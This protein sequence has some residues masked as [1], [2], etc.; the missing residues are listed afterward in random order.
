MN[1]FTVLCILGFMFSFGAACVW[2]RKRTVAEAAVMGAVLFFFTYIFG[3]MALFVIDRFSLFRA[4]AA[5]LALDISA[6]GAAVFVRRSK[7]FRLKKLIDLD[8][9]VKDMLIPL[10]V[11]IAAV[12]FVS[13]KNEIFGMGQ[14]QGVYQVQALNFMYDDNAR[15]KDIEEYHLLDDPEAKAHFEYKV[16]SMGGYDIQNHDYPE[17]VYDYNIS[18]VSGIFHGIPTYTSMLAMW[19]TLFGAENMADIETVFYILTIFL[20]YYVCR[21]LKL[22]A[23]SRICACVLTAFAPV[24][25]WVAKSTLTEMFLAV[26][27]IS[28]M[29][30]ITDD[31]QPKEKWMSVIPAA[32]FGCYHVSVFTMLPLFVMIYGGMYIFTREKQYAILTPAVTAGYL[33]SFFMMKQVQPMYTMNNYR[34]IFVGGINVNN[35]TT[36][37]T[38]FSLG[39]I[40]LS[41]GFIFIVSRTN[42]SFRAVK[43]N[44]KMA[45]NRPFRIFAALMLIIPLAFT[46]FKILRKYDSWDDASHAA[47]F[48]FGVNA[49]LVFVGLGGLLALFTTGRFIEKNSRLVVFVMF[50]YCVLIYSA[51]LRFEIQYYYYYSRYLAP[52]IPVAVIFAAL[53]LDRMGGRVL[54]P[55]AALSLVLNLPYIRWQK[56]A[57]DDTRMEWNVLEDITDVVDEDSCVVICSRYAPELWFP[58]RT[59]TDADVYPLNESDTDQFLELKRQYDKVFYIS[60]KDQPGD[61]FEIRYK[62]IV[63]HSEDDLNNTG[64]FVPM[65][66]KYME[67]QDDIYVYSYEKYKLLYEAAEDYRYFTGFSGIEGSFCWTAHE[68]TEIQGRLYPADYTAALSFGTVIPFDFLDTEEISVTMYINGEPVGTAAITPENNC[69]DITFDVP[70]ELIRDGKNVIGFETDMWNTSSVN[71]DDNRIVGIPLASVAFEEIGY[72]RPT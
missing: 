10:A 44:K 28:F 53:S 6:L 36:V 37:V 72:S 54:Y 68:K 30:F 55:A 24:V 67:V 4:A 61:G 25:I 40:V 66:L 70:E 21:N 26:I 17:T 13:V 12:P 19:G 2:L 1:T 41:C 5:A 43:F 60:D 8:M 42:K 11:C 58:L 33:A 22:K 15:Q 9:S 39:L 7:P 50:F 51:F 52:F 38:A 63:N 32:V 34:D 20:V 14:D 57:K 49:G 46:A 71:P 65:S 62:N 16:K 18:P 45:E 3:S 64:D 69:T 48:G 27:M 35:L 59:I 31:E 47:I 29:Y 23:A 56:N